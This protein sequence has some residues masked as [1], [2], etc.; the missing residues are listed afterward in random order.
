MSSTITLDLIV[1]DVMILPYWDTDHHLVHKNSKRCLLIVS[2]Y[3]QS[4]QI[5]SI[6]IASNGCKVAKNIATGEVKLYPNALRFMKPNPSI[7]VLQLLSFVSQ[8]R[9]RRTWQISNTYY[10]KLHQ[11]FNRGY[12]NGDL[13]P[14]VSRC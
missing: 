9:L 2:L 5:G 4:I 13:H 3:M 6:V 8:T 12:F 10:I 11:F 7:S 14:G 1:S